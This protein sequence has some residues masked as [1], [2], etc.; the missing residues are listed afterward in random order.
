VCNDIK[1]QKESWE[2]FAAFWGGR[3]LGFMGVGTT[4]SL[5]LQRKVSEALRGAR[6]IGILVGWDDRRRLEKH[7][8]CGILTVRHLD[9]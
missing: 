8:F 1:I 4:W 5:S 7:G 9:S 6:G 2:H 3:L